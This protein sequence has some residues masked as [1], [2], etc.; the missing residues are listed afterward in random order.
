V[1]GIA[2]LPNYRYPRPAM[3]K[4]HAPEPGRPYALVEPADEA[5]ILDIDPAQMIALYKTHGALL[6]RGFGADA[7]QFRR[8]AGKFCSTSV[9]NESP[10]R[11]P[12]LDASERLIATFF[13]YVNFAERDPE[14]PIDPPW[15]RGDFYP[16][17]PP[18]LQR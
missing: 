5:G 2:P 10:G 16:P 15:R 6:V 3:P 11:R 4:I 18:G 17:I 14:E 12:I 13:G 9:M 1:P 8:F 7:A